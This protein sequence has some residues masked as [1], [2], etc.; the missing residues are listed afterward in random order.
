MNTERFALQ[1]WAKAE[2]HLAEAAEQ[3]A[4]TTP[5]AMVHLAYYA[6]FHAARAVQLRNFGKAPKK[7]SGVVGQFG[8]HFKDKNAA[9]KAAAGDLSLVFENRLLVDYNEEAAIT[10]EQARQSL[11][12]AIA[13]LDLCASE[14]GFPRDGQPP[15]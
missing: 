9:L 1:A 4:E 8:L 3:S 13:F 2:A 6:M 12:K 11:Q 15:A 7:H 10:S 14:F 5:M